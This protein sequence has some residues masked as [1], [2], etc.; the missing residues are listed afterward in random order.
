MDPTV[1]GAPPS[2]G[3]R[4]HAQLPK[5]EDPPMTAF[6]F[7]TITSGEAAAYNAELDGLAFQTAGMSAALSSV[8][9]IAGVDG[10]PDMVAVSLNGRTV[11]FGAGVMGDQDIRF[12]DGSKLF[13]GG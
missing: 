11:M 1:G 12:A 8:S 3:S 7:E 13:V 2:R 5:S 10:A 4:G 6:T 9:Y